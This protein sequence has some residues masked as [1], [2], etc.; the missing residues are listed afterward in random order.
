MKKKQK[1]NLK[2]KEKFSLPKIQFTKKSIPGLVMFVIFATAV[3]ISAVWR[4][5]YFVFGSS[6]FFQVLMIVGI[7]SFVYL[8]F[9]YAANVKGL[10]LWTNLSIVIWLISLWCGTVSVLL[11]FGKIVFQEQIVWALFVLIIGW[12]MGSY[13]KAIEK[14]L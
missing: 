3:T 4:I 8:S 5:N 1:N 2:S 12:M 10:K 9:L 11:H 6:F 14:G 13:W 7:L